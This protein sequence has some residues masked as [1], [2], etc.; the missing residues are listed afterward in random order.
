M[1]VVAIPF[2]AVVFAVYAVSKALKAPKIADTEEES[3]IVVGT[4]EVELIEAGVPVISDILEWIEDAGERLGVTE[5][6]V[7]MRVKK[8]TFI[9]FM[10]NRVE[11]NLWLSGPVW[12]GEFPRLCS[13]SLPKD[14]P[15]ITIDRTQLSLEK[16]VIQLQKLEK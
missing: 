14:H 16:A 15:G 5:K 12:M 8:C 9:S 10:S 4:D 11:M 1:L 7:L 6:P 3:D 13:L 2:A